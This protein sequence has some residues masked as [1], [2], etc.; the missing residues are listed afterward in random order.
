MSDFPNAGVWRRLAAMV[1]DSFLIFALLFIASLIP[2]LILNAGNLGASPETNTVVHELNSPLGGWLYRFYLLAVIAGFYLA[3][4]LKSGQTLGMQA[5]KLKLVN[6]H[7]N[8]PNAKQALV[9]LLVG[10]PSLLLFGMG[11]WW[12]WLDKENRSWHDRASGTK[13]I[14]LPK[15]DKKPR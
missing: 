7:G 15:E 6:Q 10:L 1:Y 3:F 9:R 5:W 8:L 13:V 14:V 12:I 2:T 11:Y 4:W